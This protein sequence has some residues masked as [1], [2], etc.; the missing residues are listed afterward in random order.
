MF[1][2]YSVETPNN[3][4]ILFVYEKNLF[5]K[6]FS[7]FKFYKPIINKLINLKKIHY[8]SFSRLD[9]FTRFPNLFIYLF[10]FSAASRLSERHGTYTRLTRFPN[11]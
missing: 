10:K 6:I 8:F 11:D 7:M 2:N 1:L 5:L 9:F 4:I 3:L